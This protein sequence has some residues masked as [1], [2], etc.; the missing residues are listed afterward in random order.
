MLIWFFIFATF[1][2]VFAKCRFLLLKS[3]DCIILRLM[4][5]QFS[6]QATPLAKVETSGRRMLPRESWIF[7]LTHQFLVSNFNICGTGWLE[8]N[9]RGQIIISF[10]SLYQVFQNN[11]NSWMKTTAVQKILSHHEKRFP[12][13]SDQFS[14]SISLHLNSSLYNP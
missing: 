9:L 13:F 4:I 8:P 5:Y 1:Y 2:S 10:L 7:Q 11:S 3:W 6:R 14:F 12:V